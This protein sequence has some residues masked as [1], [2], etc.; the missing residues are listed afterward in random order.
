MRLLIT[1]AAALLAF[2][3]CAH[4]DGTAPAIAPLAALQPVAVQAASAPSATA[5]KLI[6]K[7]MYHEGMLLKSND[8]RTQ[9]EWDILRRDEQ[10]EISDFQNLSYR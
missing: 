3:A 8:C 5:V 6:C 10:R 4:A 9:K 2:S 1:T 7:P